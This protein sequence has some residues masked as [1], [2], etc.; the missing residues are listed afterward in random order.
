MA[1][2]PHFTSYYSYSY[3]YNY[4]EPVWKRPNMNIWTPEL[5]YS[6]SIN[7][8]TFNIKE[9]PHFEIKYFTHTALYYLTSEDK[10]R[11]IDE[12][13]AEVIAF[14]KSKKQVFSELDPYG[15]EN[16]DE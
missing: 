7:N 11:D 8:I 12:V 3:R 2:L 16:W 5:L 9:R 6:L 10:Q 4:D 14:K 13:L 15:E 1:G